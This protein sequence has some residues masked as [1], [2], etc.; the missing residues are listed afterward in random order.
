[1]NPLLAFKY[2]HLRAAFIAL[3]LGCTAGFLP[4]QT[5][6]IGNL[7]GLPAGSSASERNELWL[8]PDAESQVGLG[9]TTGST[10]ITVGALNISL[11]VFGLTDPQTFESGIYSD[12]G[13]KPGTQLAGFNPISVA[14]DPVG[15]TVYTTTLTA[16]SFA[17]A[18]NTNYWIVGH[19]G[20]GGL[21]WVV[22][23][24]STPASTVGITYQGMLESF[25]TGATWGT[26]SNY[27]YNNVG[28]DL[29]EGAP[30]PEPATYAAFGGVVALGFALWRR[31][32][33]AA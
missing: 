2:S 28:F 9:I 32:R 27:S 10:P 26:L 8:M 17:L 24:N 31:R 22:P 13:G 23:T 33:A 16:G 30:I 19:D 15:A 6:L 20:G 29:I 5:V 14:G 3:T 12:N 25:D 11:R 21:Y 7:G 18:A 1:M 4:A